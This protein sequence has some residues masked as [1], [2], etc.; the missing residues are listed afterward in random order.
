MSG[1]GAPTVAW[2]ADGI[3]HDLISS[4]LMVWNRETGRTDSMED[5]NDFYIEKALNLSKDESDHFH[6]IFERPGL[7]EDLALFDGAP[8][9]MKELHDSG[10]DVIIVSAPSGPESARG[11]LRAFARQIPW[12]SRKKIVLMHEKWRI[13]ADFWVD[14]ASHSISEIRKHQPHAI[15][16]G[17]EQP[18]NR[19]LA[20]L[21]HLLATD[22]R[23]PRDAFRN[24]TDIV[25]TFS[26]R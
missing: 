25:R 1:L 7:F 4:C 18:W 21:W 19:H 16:L 11:K 8:E 23:R 9:A 14:D 22:Y 10:H 20:H 13:N 24:I 26:G 6:G 3:I 12:L 15:T 2:D 5:I 17:L